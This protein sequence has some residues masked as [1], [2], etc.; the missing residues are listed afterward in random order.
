VQPTSYVLPVRLNEP[1]PDDLIRYVQMLSRRCDVIVVDGSAAPIFASFDGRCGPGV[2]HV[3]PDA[4]TA[5]LINGKVAGVLT[6]LRLARCERIVIADDDVRYDDDA[7]EAVV[8]ALDDADV[9]RPQNYFDPPRWHTRIDTARSLLNR[10]SGGDWPGTLAVRRS[11]LRRTGG[12]DGSVLFEN[13]ELVRTV[14]AAGGREALR[15]DI[16]VR[17]I[18]PTTRH[19]VS[20]RVRQAYD[21][22]ARPLRLVVWL[23]VLPLLTATARWGGATAVLLG[24]ALVI[25]VAEVG[26]WIDGG[27]K[28]FSFSSALLAPLW[29][30]ERGLCAWAA[31]GSRLV[32]GGVRYRGRV[33]RIAATS[34][35]VLRRRHAGREQG[36]PAAQRR[37]ES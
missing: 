10:V 3:A 25:V 9:V 21:E 14:R 8:A 2:R 19:Y 17:R 31:L 33:V 36:L 11:V 22:F 27:R 20:Q 28:V 6:G 26:R 23:S 37:L 16:F 7:L 24:V 13:L 32:W 4:E 18:P 5:G 30:V 12:Y 35:R 34:N 1:A 29:V 15:R